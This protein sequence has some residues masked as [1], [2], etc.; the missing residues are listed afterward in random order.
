M[1]NRMLSYLRHAKLFCS[2]TA[3]QQNVSSH[4]SVQLTRGLE[5]LTGAMFKLK[6]RLTEES[7]QR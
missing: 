5:A 3:V 7:D 6:L 2:D 1:V 4:L